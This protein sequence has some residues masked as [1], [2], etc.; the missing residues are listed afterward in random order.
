MEIIV[1]T[2]TGKTIALDVAASDTVLVVKAKLR[3][4]TGCLPHQQ[5][6]IFNDILMNNCR[7]LSD[8]GIHQSG[9][10]IFW[11]P[12][13]QIL[14]EPYKQ[15]DFELEVWRSSTIDELKGRIQDKTGIPAHDQHL[16]CNNGSTPTSIDKLIDG[17]SV[18]V[19]FAPELDWVN[20]N[21]Q[22][23]FR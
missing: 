23:A 22:N 21:V 13:I 3:E 16:V 20:L 1:K 17:V 18:F 6:L 9:S 11:A 12:K 5:R 4:K 7:T 10:T 14:V 19:V 8:Y 15:L 2:R